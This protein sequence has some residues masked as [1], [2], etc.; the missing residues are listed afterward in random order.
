MHI[1]HIGT[2]RLVDG[3]YAAGSGSHV[4]P[5]GG[6]MP[7]QLTDPAAS[8]PHIDAGDFLG[9]L[10]VELGNLTR[11]TAVLDAPRRVVKCSPEQWQIADIGRRRRESTRKLPLK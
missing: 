8:Q 10:E 7:M 2:T 5:F 1:G 6:E 9:N 3:G 11:P 4:G